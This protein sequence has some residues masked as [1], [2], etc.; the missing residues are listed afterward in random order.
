MTARA[1]S[2]V[3]PGPRLP[4]LSTDRGASPES[5]VVWMAVLSVE[6]SAWDTEQSHV[7]RQRDLA[8]AEAFHECSE[9]DWDG[10]GAEPANELSMKWTKRVLSTFPDCLGVPDIVFEPDGDAGLEWWRG[11]DR[12]LSV[13][14]G[15]NGELRYAARLNATRVIGTEVFADGLPRR[16]VEAALEL[17]E[18]G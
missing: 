14:V 1:A 15:R 11:P 4:Q 5:R 3:L 17:V 2:M 13:S 18:Q 7:R 9:P 8:L 6:R 16:L 10:Y 12:V